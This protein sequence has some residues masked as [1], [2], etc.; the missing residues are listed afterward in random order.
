MSRRSL[1]KAGAV[2]AGGVAAAGL[3]PTGARAAVPASGPSLPKDAIEKI[4]GAEGSGDNGVFTVEIDRDDIGTV[5]NSQGVPIKPSFQINGTVVFEAE[6]DSDG[7]YRSATLNGD[8]PFRPSELQ[9]AIDAML[10]HGL[11]F[12][13]FHQHF[14]DWDP[15]VWFMHFRGNGDARQ[16][17]RAVRA[18]LDQTSTPLPQKPP[19]HPTTPLD[20]HRLAEII[21]ATPTVG[22]D[23]VVNFDLARRNDMLLGGRQISR[24]L[25]VMT[26]VAFEPLRGTTAVVADFGMTAREVQAVTTQM[27]SKGWQIGCLYNQETDE[28]PQLYFEH[29]FK[30]GD[31]YTLAHQVR[32]ALDLMNLEFES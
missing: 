27:R 16:L 3:L 30:A 21:G 14:Y 12:Q 8:L 22:A 2:A 11:I 13:A 15:M 31:A 6:Y 28:D 24:Y 19:A 20:K 1:L 9:P 32:Q 18:V 25:N 23:G 26:S 5:V 10:A 29:V 7:S 4:I 17:A